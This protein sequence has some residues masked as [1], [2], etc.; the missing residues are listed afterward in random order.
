MSSKTRTFF[1]SLTIL[2]ILV[3][4]AVG[5]T[6]VY[7]DDDDSSETPT[8]DTSG[9]ESD[10][11][12]EDTDT[13]ACEG[14][15]DEEVAEP[16]PTEMVV[17][18]AEGGDQSQ[19]T[20]S[21]PSVVEETAPPADTGLLSQVPENTS[22]TVLNADGQAEPLATQDAAIAIAS[23]TDPIWCPQGQPPVPTPGMNG[24]TPSFGNFTDL[25]NHLVANATTFQGAGTIF[26]EQGTY[27]GLESTIDF[28]AFN[29]SN[30]SGSDLTVQG[31]WDSTPNPVDPATASTSN[32]TVP[33][34]IGSSATPWGGSLTI[35][36]IVITNPNLTGLTLYSQDNI[37]L[38]NVVVENS[39]NGDGAQ[40]N[41]GV[42]VTIAKSH[43]LRN[44]M[45]GV[46]ITAGGNVAIA[47]SEF[48]NPF[49]QRRQIRGLDIASGGS[50]SLLNVLVNGNR[51]VGAN[52]TAA[53][54]VTIGATSLGGTV[55]SETNALNGGVF[56][57]YGLKVVTP[58]AIELSNVIA[59]NNFLW[60]ADLDA[61]GDVAI[62]NS[63]FNANSTS[64]PTFIDDTG[65]LVTSRGNVALNNVTANDN[66]LIGA[67]I[68]AVGTV[69]ISNST[70]SNTQGTTTSGTTT[71]FHGLGL[72]VVS[73]NNIN[74]TNVTASNNYI[75]GAHLE[76]GGEITVRGS[77][78]NDNRTP[79]AADALGRGL[80]MISVGNASIATTMLDN[81][82]TFGAFIQAGGPHVFLDLLTATRNGTDGV[83]VQAVCTHLNGGT[84][85]GNGQYGLNLTTSALD[86]VV[87]PTFG[88]NTG[89]DISPATPAICPPVIIITPPLNAGNPVST[90]SPQGS[91]SGGNAA[92]LQQSVSYAPVAQ[93]S[94]GAITAPFGPTLNSLFGITRENIGNGVVT[95]IFVGQYVYVY[96]VYQD[97][98]SIDNLQIILLSPAPLP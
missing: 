41:A 81:N 72:E 38:S 85:T 84:Y 50:V 73:S 12:E 83:Q 89:G 21:V 94:G 67:V 61:G 42:D 86:L 53:K 49:N 5:P 69:T 22:V 64:S 4:S 51:R 60:G 70:F 75:F 25:L 95:S 82:Q 98:S 45:T 78:F 90:N 62:F 37:N 71:T 58:D 28:N 33:I 57:G 27:G 55:F 20:E 63:I 74:L 34:L 40:L 16:Q 93:H 52:I 96:T 65:L 17:P 77:F 48:S 43:F 32:F 18:I 97:D 23:T 68:D 7:A 47:D 1:L 36:N 79:S 46:R 26:V 3:F 54:R 44:G 11:D 15:S 6:T 56:Y 29:L 14:N 13:S 88:G 76:S 35:N 8:A 24:C 91:T 87:M 92:N 39:A 80:E 9:C 2:A 31:G 10:S 30:I 66:R 59:N 19:P